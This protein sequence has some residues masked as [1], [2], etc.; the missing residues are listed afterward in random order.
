[1]ANGEIDF[2]TLYKTAADDFENA[3]TKLWKIDLN[4]SISIKYL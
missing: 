1:M 2:P 3:K 4:D